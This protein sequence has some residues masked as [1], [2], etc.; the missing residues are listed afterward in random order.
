MFKDTSELINFVR[1]EVERKGSV[2]IYCFTNNKNEKKYIGQSRNIP[3]RIRDHV[4]DAFVNKVDFYF[5]RALRKH[6]VESFDFEI[7]ET[8]LIEELDEREAHY[9]FAFDTLDKGY[10]MIL[11]GYRPI[12]VLFTQD[13]IQNIIDDIRESDW[14][15]KEL[16]EKYNLSEGF[17]KQINR[18]ESYRKDSE[19]YPL[20]T[21]AFEIPDFDLLLSL[22][23]RGIGYAAE[24]LA[25]S[26]A[27]IR[28]W[29]TYYG[30]E[31]N[32]RAVQQFLGEEE[33]PGAKNGHYYGKIKVT[34]PTEEVL[35]FDSI[36]SAALFFQDSG[37][38]KGQLRSIEVSIRSALNGRR[39]HFFNYLFEDLG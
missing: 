32:H 19:T 8:C 2:G 27:T 21:K 39:K 28:R 30:L 37:I 15:L 29:L 10:N 20:R 25:V 12:S 11:P 38:S 4:R 17:M 34:S 24:E 14:T 13:E 7:L 23:K 18:G 35:Y 3:Q 9:I 16:G 31:P 22:A 6:G 26:E 36:P 1:E 33:R 5:Y